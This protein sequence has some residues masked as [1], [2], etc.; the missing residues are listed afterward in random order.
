MDSV[1]DQFLSYQTMREEDIPDSLKDDRDG[2]PC[3]VDKL[4]GYLK[5]LVQMS[6]NLTF[7]LK[8]PMLY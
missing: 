3:N 2:G 8:L 5:G 4:W 6:V 7:Y 1:N